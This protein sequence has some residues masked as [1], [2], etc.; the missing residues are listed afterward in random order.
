MVSSETLYRAHVTFFKN[1]T[2]FGWFLLLPFVSARRNAFH[3]FKGGVK[4]IPG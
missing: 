3:S 1:D 2:T 4:C